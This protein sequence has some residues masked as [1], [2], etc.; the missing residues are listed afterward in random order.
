[1]PYVVTTTIELLEGPLVRLTIVETNAA[2]ASE[3]MIADQ[4]IPR[5]GTVIRQTSVL[6]AGTGTAVAPVL[7][8][9][10]NPVGTPDVVCQVATPGAAVV[11]VFGEAPYHTYPQVG[12]PGRLFHRSR[13]NAAADNTITTVYLIVPGWP[14]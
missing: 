2:A 4:R 14:T 7:G 6:Q 1:M 10:T 11:D 12:A 8:T 5:T 3:T 9:V 13:V